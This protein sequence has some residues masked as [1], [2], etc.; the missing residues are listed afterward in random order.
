MTATSV[1]TIKQSSDHLRGS[2]KAELASD[3]PMFAQDSTHVLK[4][5]GIYQQDDRD[6]RRERKLAGADLA[7]SC[8]VRCSVPGGQLRAAQWA[9]INAIADEIGDGSLRLTTR[10]GVQFHFVHK[11]DLKSLVGRLNKHF[12]TTYAACGDVV[13]N[14]MVSSAPVAGRDT[15]RLESIG[16]TLANRFRP[17]AES[18]WELWVDGERA[19][20]AGPAPRSEDE[21]EPI[22]GASYLPRKF[23]IGVAAPGDNSID[24]YTQDLG[25][26]PVEDADGVAGLVVLAGGG[27]G[28]S[29]NDATTFPRLAEPLAWVPDAEVGEVAE[30]VVT[31]FR[32]FGDREDRKH[33]RLKYLV[34][35]RGISWLRT[36]IESRIGR[37]LLPPLA[38]P[39]WNGASD[40][41]G[42]HRQD[43]NRRFYGI[44]VPSGRL[45]NNGSVH[46][47][48]AVAAVLAAGLAN[49]VR[50]TPRQDILLCGIAAADRAAVEAVLGEHG[51]PRL[52][53]L[54][55]STRSSI[56][57]PA[58]PTCS[59]ALGEAERVL[60]QLADTLD[61]LLFERGMSDVRIETRMTGCPN[62]CARP[63]VAEL[64]VV[65]RSKTDYDIWVGGSPSGSRLAQ[66]VAEGV[67]FVKLRHALVPLFDSYEA[68]RTEGEAFG[69]WAYRVG[70]DQLASLVPI[71]GKRQK[72]VIE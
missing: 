67:P 49:E 61:S 34:E 55:L 48:S 69:D 10:Q 6:V 8:M 62:G 70:R 59:Q 64:G 17:E 39:A 42:W 27:L 29:H 65:A 4:F 15:E 51:V 33:A 18:Y 2:L 53:Q 35:E 60:P 46:R 56:A 68:T 36:E 12:V 37:R 44:P 32:D 5:H 7:Y 1:E 11:G 28:M 24:V 54:S 71:V 19:V 23:K 63:Y 31:I 66:V 40:F 47:R 20:S 58:L 26:I 16:R 52:D 13:R 9:A 72:S 38:I 41:H 3:A 25:F 22:Y 45:V 30:A 14:V 57:C 50:I 21:I 43:D